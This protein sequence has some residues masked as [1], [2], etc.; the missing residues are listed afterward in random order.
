MRDEWIT[1]KEAARIMSEN[2]GHPVSDNYVRRL[3]LSGK[4]RTKPVDERT[5]LYLKRDVEGYR[6]AERA[7]KAANAA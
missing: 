2:S 3:A 6:V 4:L 5:K 7:K 1:S